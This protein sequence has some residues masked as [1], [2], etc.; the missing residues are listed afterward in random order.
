MIMPLAF[1]DV[2][3]DIDL[4]PEALNALL[5]IP[6]PNLKLDAPSDSFSSL[7]AVHDFSQTFVGARLPLFYSSILICCSDEGRTRLCA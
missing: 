3:L 2:E 4:G 7:V 6:G 5:F 1:L